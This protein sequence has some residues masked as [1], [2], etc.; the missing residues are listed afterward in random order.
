MPQDNITY[1]SDGLPVPSNPV[2]ENGIDTGDLPVP[3][4]KKESTTDLN[5]PSAPSSQSGETLTDT[6]LPKQEGTGNMFLDLMGKGDVYDNIPANAPLTLPTKDQE[7]GVVK[8]YNKG[9]FVTPEHFPKDSQ[10]QKFLNGI[11]SALDVM[12]N[13]YG[14]LGKIADKAFVGSAAMSL[15]G[16]GQL[17]KAMQDAQDYND[18]NAFIKGLAGT[19]KAAFGAAGTVLPSI[20]AFNTAIQGVEEVAPQEYLSAVMSPL[21]SLLANH[22]YVLPSLSGSAPKIFTI[23]NVGEGTKALAELGDVAIQMLMAKGFESTALKIKTGEPFTAEDRNNTA[24]ALGDIAEAQQDFKPETLDKISPDISDDKKIEIAPL[25]E[26]K[27][28]AETAKILAQTNISKLD[29]NFHDGEKKKIADA[30]NE[31]KKL[32]QQIKDIIAPTKIEGRE[33]AISKDE[34]ISNVVGRDATYQN[35]VGV[36]E[37][38]DEGNF[39][40]NDG[41]KQQI[42]P[43][44]D[45]VNPTETIGALGVEVAPEKIGKTVV[46]V[47]TKQGDITFRNRKYFVSFTSDVNDKVGTKVYEYTKD[48]NLLSVGKVGK[49]NDIIQQFK[50]EHGISVKHPKDK[51][52]PIDLP[53]DESKPTENVPTTPTPESQTGQ[54]TEPTSESIGTINGGETNTVGEGDIKQT[55]EEVPQEEKKKPVTYKLTIDKSDNGFDVNF[56][57]GD[58]GEFKKNTDLSK[59]FESK[60]EAVDYAKELV[61]KFDDTKETPPKELTK[62]GGTNENT[63]LVDANVENNPTPLEQKIDAGN[64]LKEKTKLAKDKFLDSWNKAQENRKSSD[65]NLSITKNSKEQIERQAQL[66]REAFDNLVDYAREFINEKLGDLKDFL[67]S[68]PEKIIG[69]KAWNVA[70]GKEKYEEAAKVLETINK[71]P[72]ILDSNSTG[73]KNEITKAERELQGRD[74]VEVELKR[75]F[76]EAFD[77]GKEAVDSG[78]I[79]P[80]LLA[81][82]LAEKPR[83][84][85]AEESVA[86]LYDRMRLSNEHQ[87]VMNIFNEATEKSDEA[88]RTEA[89]VRLASIEEAKNL[90]DEASRRT[91]YEQGLGLAIRRLMI[92]RDYSL[93]NIIQRAKVANEGKD[94][95]PELRAKLESLSKEKD[96]LEK[97]LN[98]H[99]KR[100]KE[101]ENELATR[102]ERKSV[103]DQAKKLADKVRTLKTK[104][105]VL[106]DAQGN[107]IIVKESGF[108][109]EAVELVAQAIEKGGELAEAIQ[110]GIEHLRKQKFYEEL[111]DEDRAAVEKQFEDYLNSSAKDEAEQLEKYKEKLSKKNSDLTAKLMEQG[112]KPKAKEAK[113]IQ[114]VDEEARSLQAQIKKKEYQLDLEVLKLSEKNKSR[115]EKFLDWTAKWRR[116][117]LLTSITTLGKLTSAATQRIITTPIEEIEGALLSK[118]PFIR[119]IAAK[120]PREGNFSAKAEA[121]SLVQLFRKATYKDVWETAKTG[122]SEL[123]YLY[124][125]GATLPP[126][127]LDFFGQLHGALK[128]APKRA[129][130]Y[131]ALEKRT[132]FAIKNGV[133]VSDPA[134]QAN[135]AASAYIDANRAILMHDNGFTDAYKMLIKNLESKKTGGK[136]TATAAKVLFPIVKIPV[137][138]VGEASSYAGGALKAI[139]Q[140]A[141]AGGIDKMTPEQADY[142]LRA[143]KKQGVG[144]VLMGLGYM[145]ANSIGGYYQNGE[146]RSENDAQAG[147]MKLFGRNIPRWLLHSPA[148]EMLQFGATVRRVHDAYTTHGKEGGALVGTF[149][150]ATGLLSEV[151]FFEQ[152]AQIQ[153]AVKSPSAAAGYLGELASS[154][155]VPPDL[156]K[157]ASSHDVDKNGN[158]ISRKMEGFSSHIKS[159]IPVLREQLPINEAKEWG[160]KQ[161]SIIEKYEKS[162]SLSSSDVKKDLFGITDLNKSQEDSYELFNKKLQAAREFG[163]ES[164]EFNL[165]KSLSGMISNQRKAEILKAYKKEQGNKFDAY[166]KFARSHRI[167]SQ[168]VI[169][170]LTNK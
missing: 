17:Q 58:G 46:P 70:S 94:I 117:I 99:V 154:M 161:Q 68:V 138:Y 53:I 152:P 20:M 60:Q 28:D 135:L 62:E 112:L 122:K 81:K 8:T 98:D 3:S 65:K 131:R 156:S 54:P 33:I 43:I 21:S 113:P 91:G 165:T 151:P 168:A 155:V 85:N 59:S 14:E 89:A 34:N 38:D 12:P 163:N 45:K 106:K 101:L 140:V 170:L 32:N 42:L 4:K 142:T 119:K 72:V 130:F 110:A 123:D 114:K 149:N 63:P 56:S 125:K 22:V 120:A 78:K 10:A 116:A 41:T 132:E 11:Y 69:E 118:T 77:K 50:D 25:I 16:S 169:N 66:D 108:Y 96:A 23:G 166:I 55:P 80:R 103:K 57:D 92:K 147:G 139:V 1:N 141:I 102:P 39:I 160:Q 128:I 133:D 107:P 27:Q 134:I 167:I 52:E 79:D 7:A 88:G 71:E 83:A 6:I 93:L 40:F 87:Q 137:N 18:P 26:R 159:K 24:Q 90:N 19:T 158:P 82:T 157:Y 29:E 144:A 5:P 48:G 86:L 97:K 74:E 95:S 61:K 84:L 143:L 9:D 13:P 37:K 145:Y 73:I 15:Q 36:I 64:T 109:N 104:P 124:G 146:K 35:K 51:T 150:A 2:K 148:M 47:I 164:R 67:E 136:I 111:K 126:T 76:P 115:G 31:I 105:L 49:R 75:S 100:I 30:D 127:M 44:E 121:Q 162:K 153:E 129:E